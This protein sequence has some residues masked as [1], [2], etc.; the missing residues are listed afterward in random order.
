MVG[1]CYEDNTTFTRL[2]TG[3]EDINE[4]TNTSLARTPWR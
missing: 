3:R 2:V 4:G 1:T